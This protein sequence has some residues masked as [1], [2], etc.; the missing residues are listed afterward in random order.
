MLFVIAKDDRRLRIAT[1]KTLEGAMPD[2]LAH[3]T[4]HQAVPPALHQGGYAGGLGVG[5]DKI[6]A[7]I[8]GEN[9]PLPSVAQQP[10]SSGDLAWPDSLIFLAFA[11]PTFAAV[12]RGIFGD[13]LGTPL[14]VLGARGLAHA[15]TTVFWIAVGIV[16]IGIVGLC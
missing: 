1:A 8:R 3:H 9:L 16:L 2:L 6:L 5:V 10:D 7:R 4:L 15:L 11:V 13:K 14:T 12:L